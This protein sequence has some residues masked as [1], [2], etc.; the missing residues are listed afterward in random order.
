MLTWSPQWNELI[1]RVHYMAWASKSRWTIK[2]DH[3]YKMW[4]AET[5]WP[6]QKL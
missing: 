1:H 4:K 5:I 6:V 2:Y 3:K